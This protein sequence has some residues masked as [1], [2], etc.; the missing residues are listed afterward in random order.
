VFEVPVVDMDDTIIEVHGYAKQRPGFGDT[1][2]R[3]LN[4]LCAISLH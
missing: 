4:E 2:V 1:T 3:G